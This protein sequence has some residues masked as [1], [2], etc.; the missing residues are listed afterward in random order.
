MI[1]CYRYFF[2]LRAR[3]FSLA[4]IFGLLLWPIAAEARYSHIVFDAKTGKVLAQENQHVQRH[5]A[6]LTKMMTVYM[7]FDQVKNR[8]MQWDQKLRVSKRAARQSPSKLGLNPGDTITLRNATLALITRSANDMAVTIAE[9][10]GQ[11]EA[12]FAQLMTQRARALGMSRTTFKNASGLPAK[13]QLTT[14]RDMGVLGQA[15]IR[16]FPDMYKMFNTESFV[17]RGQRIHNHNRLLG[18]Y[19]GLDGIKTGYI[20]ASGFNLVASAERGNQ[21][22]VG[23]VMG[24]RSA[25]WRDR[26][27]QALLDQS[28]EDLGIGRGYAAYPVKPAQTASVTSDAENGRRLAASADALD[29]EETDLAEAA[30]PALIPTE[31]T[32]AAAATAAPA[33]EWGLQIGAFRKRELA[34]AAAIRA[35]KSHRNLQ[36]TALHISEVASG[37]RRLYRARLTGLNEP[38]ATSAC[39]SLR[40]QKFDCKIIRPS[41]SNS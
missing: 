34:Q 3:I 32:E 23:V 5:P 18:N 8:K 30:N 20:R 16:D 10:I 38:E 29:T 6:S 31:E 12:N 26:R 19:P 9:A 1:E 7:V 13:G 24:G 33:K 36:K 11:S 21:R 28:F 39:N 41:A 25:S 35:Q 14:A 2:S 17:F 15:L 27:M 22:L 40:R 4:L 37:N